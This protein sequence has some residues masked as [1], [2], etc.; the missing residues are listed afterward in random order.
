MNPQSKAFAA[1]LGGTIIGPVIEVQIVNILDQ[2][3]LEIANPS[4]NER[5]STSYVMIS[6]GKN[7]FFHFPEAVLESSAESL[8]GLQKAEGR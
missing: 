6:R 1:I 3:G 8:S 2:Y 7:R 4:P 5:G